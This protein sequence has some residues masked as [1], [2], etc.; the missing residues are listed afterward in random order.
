MLKSLT[1]FGSLYLRNKVFFLYVLVLSFLVIFFI[2][3]DV[4][5]E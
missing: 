1:T 2:Y 5:I 4:V 3:F